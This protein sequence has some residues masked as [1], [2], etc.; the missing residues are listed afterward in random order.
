VMPKLVQYCD[1]V[2]GNVWSAETMLNIPV[3]E[4]IKELNKKEVYLQQAKET[5]QKIIERFP[6]CKVVANTFRFD[7]DG[8]NY[9]AS[10]FANNLLYVSPE[11]KTHT[12]IDKVGS[13]D[14]FMAGLIYGMYNH[15]PFQQV[16]NFATAAAFQKLFIEGDT[17]YKTVEE[18]RSFIQHHE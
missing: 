11:Y 10:I 8:I 1:V 6:K 12:V 3:K 5:S 2:M 13:G 4:N 16:V 18:I 14:C 15:L 9:Y 17:N 7:D